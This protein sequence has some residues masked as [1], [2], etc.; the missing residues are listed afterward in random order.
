MTGPS[1]AWH[2]IYNNLVYEPLAF[3]DSLRYYG[4]QGFKLPTI[5]EK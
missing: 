5:R 1:S 3:K 4:L 2:I